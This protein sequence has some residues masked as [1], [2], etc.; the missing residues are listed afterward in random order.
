MLKKIYVHNFRSLQNFELDLT[1]IKSAL[2]LGKNGSGKTSVFDA[3]EIFQ[4]IA[5]GVTQI[6]NLVKKQD[7]AFGDNTKP[8]KFELD[9]ELDSKQ[10][11]YTIEI[12]MPEGFR[13]PKIKHEQLKFDGRIIFEREGGRTLLNSAAEFTLD[14]H[15][16]GLPLISVR[17]A[18]EPIAQFREWL[19]SIVILSP[20]P[21]HFATTSKGE[22]SYLDREGQHLLDWITELLA[23]NPNLYSEI[24][25]FLTHRLNDFSL[26]KF[27]PIGADEK[28][29]KVEF[30]NEGKKRIEL[31]FSQL[32]DGER[33]FMLAAGLVA[34]MNNG[35]PILCLWDEPDNFISLVELSHFILACRKAAE[36][37]DESVQ[38]IMASHNATVINEFSKHNTFIMSRNSHLEPSRNQK[39]EAKTYISVTLIEAFENGELD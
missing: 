7:F 30:K 18:N 1:H 12:E 36:T 33:V 20:C 19:S 16:F 24:S 13:E 9:V 38:L 5:Q 8:M 35:R 11:I 14:W 22:N 15:H 2:L 39:L 23:E 27:N 21:K 6:K 17:D 34:R 3:I 25:E 10:F 37:S 31:N 32:S 29:L 4:Q 28:E 26:F